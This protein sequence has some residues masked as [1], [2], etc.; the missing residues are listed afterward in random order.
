MRNYITT[1]LAAAVGA[2]AVELPI[3]WI[4]KLIL[5]SQ[6]TIAKKNEVTPPIP[7]RRTIHNIL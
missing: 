2:L 1:L 3:K 4:E 7:E 5:L 6:G